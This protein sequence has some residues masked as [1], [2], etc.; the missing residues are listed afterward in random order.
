[1]GPPMRPEMAIAPKSTKFQISA[2]WSKKGH[3][4]SGIIR[5]CSEFRRDHLVFSFPKL[6]FLDFGVL[7]HFLGTFSEKK[8]SQWRNI[9]PIG[10]PM[11]PHGGP[12]GPW[13][14]MG[15]HGPPWGPMGP[16]GGPIGPP[17][18]PMGSHGVPWTLSYGWTLS[19]FGLST[20]YG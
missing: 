13:G 3:Q 9:G 6:T 15:P 4:D 17:W 19:L 16:Y 18:G 2:K 1:M 10:A 11:G 8:I 12:W 5:F 20:G 7:F 14:P